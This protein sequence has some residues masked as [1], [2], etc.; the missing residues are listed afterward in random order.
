MKTKECNERLKTYSFSG[1]GNYS[2][3]FGWD[4]GLSCTLGKEIMLEVPSEVEGIIDYT[5]N[6]YGGSRNVEGV[7][8]AISPEDARKKLD[9][10]EDSFDVVEYEQD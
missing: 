5:I 6:E 7:I 1:F 8:S 4:N 9:E 3:R 10:L 2:H